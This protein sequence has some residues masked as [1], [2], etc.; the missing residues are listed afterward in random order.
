MLCPSRL[1]QALTSASF[2][3]F[4][5][6]RTRFRVSPSIT[7]GV[8]SGLS[9]TEIFPNQLS[10]VETAHRKVFFFA[11]WRGARH[12]SNLGKGKLWRA[13]RQQVDTP[14]RA[15]NSRTHAARAPRARRARARVAGVSSAGSRKASRHQ[16]KKNEDKRWI[17][18]RKEIEGRLR[19][20]S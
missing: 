20:T 4:I 6:C 8:N 5:N 18:L 2:I 14:R 9:L 7:K 19:A 3:S 13:R 1:D 16:K 17:R 12:F 15:R 10:A 11:I